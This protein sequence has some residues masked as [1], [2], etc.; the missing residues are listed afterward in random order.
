MQCRH[1]FPIQ[2]LRCIVPRRTQEERAFTFLSQP[3][4]FPDGIQM[5]EPRARSQTATM[6]VFRK[7]P[8]KL[9][10]SIQSAPSATTSNIPRHL[11]RP[12]HHRPLHR[13]PHWLPIRPERRQNPHPK[14]PRLCAQPPLSPVLPSLH[15]P[16]LRRPLKKRLQVRKARLH[17]H[18]DTHRPVRF[19]EPV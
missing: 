4:P 16:K 5:G 3:Q 13:R 9:R 6:G 11:R 17:H 8:R 1:S 12:P 19:P 7:I 2:L 10:R 18:A 14:F 15:P